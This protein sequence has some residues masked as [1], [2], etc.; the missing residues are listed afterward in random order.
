[1]APFSFVPPRL[2]RPD[3]KHAKHVRFGK[4]LLREEAHCAA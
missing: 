2:S 1:M 3:I 4:Y